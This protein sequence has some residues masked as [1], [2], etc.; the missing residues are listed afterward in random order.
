MFRFCILKLIITS[1]LCFASLLLLAHSSSSRH[2][3]P[4][5]HHP[6]S[7]AGTLSPFIASPRRPRSSLL[8][9]ITSPPLTPRCLPLPRHHPRQAPPLW[10]PGASRFT[11]RCSEESTFC[12]T[13]YP[14]RYIF[15]TFLIR[16]LL[17]MYICIILLNS[18]TYNLIYT[19]TVLLHVLIFCVRLVQYQC[20]KPSTAPHRQQANINSSVNVTT[21]R[22]S[23]S[24]THHV[25][26][27]TQFQLNHF[28][29]STS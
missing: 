25:S 24:P 28:I 11:R 27:G 29:K 15:K 20:S 10:M 9:P 7:D 21:L 8:T 17:M 13:E 12:L 1:L 18:L 14:Q 22:G 26:F 2:F 16:I 5:Q 3:F 6:L 23:R 19:I 4:P